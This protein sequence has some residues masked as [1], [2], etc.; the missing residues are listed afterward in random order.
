MRNLDDDGCEIPDGG[1]VHVPAPMFLMDATRRGYDLDDDDS[2]TDEVQQ[3]GSVRVPLYLCDEALQRAI[4]GVN[5]ADHQ[6]GFRSLSDAER[7]VVRDARQ[8]MIDRATS[9]W[10]KQRNA[11]P[12][13]FSCPRCRGTGVDPIDGDSCA[14]CDGVGS[15]PTPNILS[16]SQRRAGERY[17]DAS[18]RLDWK[19]R[20]PDEDDDD[21]EL[22]NARRRRR[23]RRERER[24]SDDASITGARTAVRDAYFAM[25]RRAERAWVTPARDAAEPS[26][27]SSPTEWAAHRRDV[28]PDHDLEARLRGHLQRG[29]S[30]RRRDDAWSSYKDRISR[31]WERG[32]TDPKEADR[33]MRQAKSENWRHG[34]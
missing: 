31:A 29:E 3:G 26:N 6:P 2:I 23:E 8:Q 24:R 22:D 33:I 18:L 7:A 20:K 17:P 30:Q 9:A 1:S 32:R 34:A 15:I 13:Q 27:S 10:E 19:R 11:N 5:L 4:G 28:E 21:D 25:V 14:E 12:P 16:S